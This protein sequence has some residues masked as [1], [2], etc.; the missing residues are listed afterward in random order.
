MDKRP[1]TLTIEQRLKS[2]EDSREYI[3]SELDS[4]VSRMNGLRKIGE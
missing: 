1:E 2:L 4:L 3:M